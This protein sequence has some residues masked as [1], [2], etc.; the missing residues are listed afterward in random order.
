M[1]LSPRAA[2]VATA[3]LVHSLFV[4]AV[5]SM[6]LGLATGMQIG[7]GRFEDG[8][9]AVADAILVL[10]FPLLHSALLTG[11]GRRWLARLSPVG[12]GRTLAVS[13]YV[14]V[15]SLQLLAVFWLW[16]PS[17]FVLHTPT[18]PVGLL[19][20]ALFAGAWGFLVKALFDAGIALQSGAAGW[21]ALW[22]GRAV[23]HGGMPTRG[24]FAA[25]RQPIYL[26]FALVLWTAPTWSLDWL[27]L[28]AGWTLYCLLGPRLKEARWEALFGD[29][30]RDYRRK[31]PY[32]LPGLP[33]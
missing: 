9:A 3:V 10:Q 2:A 21:L 22:R 1:R 14:G 11:R 30:F 32:F 19:Q 7:L 12:H 24:L 25:C 13:T 4:A 33:R 28:G 23:D 29:R 20:Y 8:A 27:G 5:G 26:G 17:G 18:G 6:A 15:G 16:S 31:V